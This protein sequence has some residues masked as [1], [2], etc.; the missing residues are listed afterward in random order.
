MNNTTAVHYRILKE[1]ETF[2]LHQGFELQSSEVFGTP[3]L[4][5]IAR[6]DCLPIYT[7]NTELARGTAEELRSF[8]LGWHKAKEYFSMLRLVDD[9]KLTRAEQDYRNRLLADMIKH[10]KKKD[11]SK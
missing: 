8:L 11:E 3:S 4:A 1:L 7:R 6:D 5:L 10:G 2:C 9:K